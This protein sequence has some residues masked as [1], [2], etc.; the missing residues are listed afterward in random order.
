MHTFASQW[1]IRGTPTTTCSKAGLWRNAWAMAGEGRCAQAGLRGAW[2]TFAKP[3]LVRTASTTPLLQWPSTST[4]FAI[5]CPLPLGP[6]TPS[7]TWTSLARTLSSILFL[8][9]DR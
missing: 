5:V 9:S 4:R 7:P 8:R 1:G 6:A 3:C 2:C